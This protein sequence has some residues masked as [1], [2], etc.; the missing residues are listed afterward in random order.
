MGVLFKNICKKII[1]HQ[2]S[3]GFFNGYDVNRKG[4][5]SFLSLVDVDV[6]ESLIESNSEIDW[7][8]TEN[9]NNFFHSNRWS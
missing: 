6:K 7:K 4:L 1:S 3:V 2:S 8:I 9:W 5:K